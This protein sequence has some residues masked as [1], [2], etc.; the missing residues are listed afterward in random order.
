MFVFVI[1]TKRSKSKPNQ[2]QTDIWKKQMSGGRLN[3]IPWKT[4]NENI[5]QM[6]KI[7]ILNMLVANLHKCLPLQ[8]TLRLS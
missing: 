3:S 4:E 5:N 1:G 2:N 8:P 7:C 6:V